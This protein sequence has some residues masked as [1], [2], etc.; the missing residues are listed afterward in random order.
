MLQDPANAAVWITMNREMDLVLMMVAVLFGMCVLAIILF[1]MLKW[2]YTKERRDRL[3]TAQAEAE[4]ALQQWTRARSPFC[5]SSYSSS[6]KSNC[7]KISFRSF[8]FDYDQFRLWPQF[9]VI[10][11]RSQ[12]GK[13]PLKRRDHDRIWVTKYIYTQCILILPILILEIAYEI[14]IF[15]SFVCHGGTAVFV[16]KWMHFEQIKYSQFYNHT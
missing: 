5:S 2:H 16:K 1:A 15:F 14:I 10:L 9:V 11:F 3:R 13:R 8:W 6:P 7:S 12:I 4:A